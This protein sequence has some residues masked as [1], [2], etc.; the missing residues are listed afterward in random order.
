MK[1]IIT[2]EMDGR[3]VESIGEYSIDQIDKMNVDFYNWKEAEK[4]KSS[5]SK[6]HINYYDRVIFN[7]KKH[8]L[9]IDFG[10]YTYFGLVKTNK[11]EWEAIKNHQ[12]KPV[13]LEV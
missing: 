9:I 11:K 2:K 12:R 1:F 6:Y 8:R 4:K 10:D 3:K 13:D 7:E 5:D